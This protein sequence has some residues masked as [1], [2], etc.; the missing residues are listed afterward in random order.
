MNENQKPEMDQGPRAREPMFLLP[1]VVTA[2]AG[3]MA[4]VH[5]AQVLVLNDQAELELMVWFSFFPVRL[6]VP[7]E[8][9]GGLLPLT[10]TLFTHAFLHAGWEHL[11]INV[12]WLAIFGTPVARRYGAR[13][14]LALFLIGAAAGAALNSRATRSLGEAVDRDLRAARS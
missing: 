1:G 6:L 12:A 11:L 14:F 5:L 8:I 13:A 10:W 9:P 4:L 3:L 2:L 7:G